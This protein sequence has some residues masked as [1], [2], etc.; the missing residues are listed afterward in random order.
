[1]G[2]SFGRLVQPDS[3]QGQQTSFNTST[4]FIIFTSTS[5]QKATGI[6][7][8][9]SFLSSFYPLFRLALLLKATFMSDSLQWFHP[10]VIPEMSFCKYKSVVEGRA[11]FMAQQEV[12]VSVRLSWLPPQE[13]FVLEHLGQSLVEGPVELL[14]DVPCNRQHGPQV[15]VRR[16]PGVGGR[17][18][19]YLRL[20]L[21][22]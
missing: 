14:Q 1:M 18:L 21:L 13:G 9:S 12:S 7:F 19:G 2:V 8:L 17:A 6:S 4:E 22:R 3:R 15:Q 16:P 20:L 5:P 11:T 10:K